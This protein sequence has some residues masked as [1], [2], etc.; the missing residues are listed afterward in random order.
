[1]MIGSF[2]LLKRNTINVSPS[3]MTF[4]GL[5]GIIL[6][7]LTKTLFATQIFYV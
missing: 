1:M 3:K 7:E 6:V 2:L 5:F 4:V